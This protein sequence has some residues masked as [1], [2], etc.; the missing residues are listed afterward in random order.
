MDLEKSPVSQKYL[1][2][3]YEKEFLIR[4]IVTNNLGCADTAYQNLK[5]LKSC[6]LAVPTAFTPNGDG[7]NDFLFPINAFKAQN[8]EFKVF[9]RN[10]QLIY[11][12]KDWLQKWNGTFNGE[13]QDS[14]VYVWTMRYKHAD[15]GK[16]HFQKGSSVLIR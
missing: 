6:Y 13:P 2:N 14:G 5:V 7:I 15:T 4:Q 8:L 9:N 11:H 3:N 16:K 1:A 10:G 12:S